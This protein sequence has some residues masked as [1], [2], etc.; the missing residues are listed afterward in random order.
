MNQWMLAIWSLSLVFCALQESL[1]PPVLWNFC[2][3]IPLTS[4]VRFPEDSQSICQ[5]PWLRS[6]LWSLKLLQ[7]C[8]NFFCI[9]VLQFVDHPP[10][11]SV[12]G[13]MVTS[14]KRTYTSYYG[15]QDCCYQCPCPCSR[16]LLT[17][18]SAGDPQTLAGRSD[19]VSYRV[20]APFCWV[21]VHTQFC[22][23]PPR[24]SVSPSL[25]EVL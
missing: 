20:T 12:V 21:L 1:F 13:L 5:I 9:I 2:N 15:S 17:H 18:S 6:L 7:Q 16:P 4:K 11:G 8:K 19:L 24:I 22:L 14:F 10:R 3:Q 25:V 23:C